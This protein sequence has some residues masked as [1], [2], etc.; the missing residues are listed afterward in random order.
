MSPTSMLCCHERRHAKNK[1]EENTREKQSYPA[2]NVTPSREIPSFDASAPTGAQ[3][4]PP[5]PH[6]AYSFV[7]SLAFLSNSL[8]LSLYRFAAVVFT[9]SSGTGS[10]K[11]CC[12]ALM[13][14]KS[15][16]DGFHESCLVKP[17]H[18]DPFSSST[19]GWKTLVLKMMVGAL[20]GYSMGNSSRSWNLPPCDD[21][22]S[23][24]W[25][26]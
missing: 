21:Y 18:I 20:N 22:L 11:T 9:A 19:L 26:R 16:L 17:K 24:L 12:A 25:T 1:K 14:D 7:H 3:H 6:F 4:V 5:L 15:L 23:T 10:A 13:T 2:P 8:R